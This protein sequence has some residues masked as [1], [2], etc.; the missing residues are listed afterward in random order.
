MVTDQ[1]V[2]LFGAYRLA[3]NLVNVF[4]SFL[5]ANSQDHLTSLVAAAVDRFVWQSNLITLC[6]FQLMPAQVRRL[7]AD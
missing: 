2:N 7:S 3:I 6:A 5:G 4:A 1:V